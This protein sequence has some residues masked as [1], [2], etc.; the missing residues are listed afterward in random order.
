MLSMALGDIRVI[1]LAFFAGAESRSFGPQVVLGEQRFRLRREGD[2]DCWPLHG[3]AR[4]RHHLCSRRNGVA[5][6][7][8]QRK[9]IL[10][11]SS[12]SQMGLVAATLGKGLVVGIAFLTDNSVTGV[13]QS[14]R[15]RSGG[16][17]AFGTMQ[18]TLDIEYSRPSVDFEWFGF[19]E[20]DEVAGEGAAELLDDGAIKIEFEYKNGDEAASPAPVQALDPDFVAKLRDVVGLYVDPPAHAIALSADENSQIHAL[21]RTQRGPPAQEGLGRDHDARL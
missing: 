12:I 21:D 17:I 2:R 13:S 15:E 18:A 5:I 1:C 9:T 4:H 16:E 10:A 8:T 3:A 20:G 7:L 14:D 6:G 11:Y 19:D